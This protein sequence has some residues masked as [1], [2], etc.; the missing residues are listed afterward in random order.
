MSAG[1]QNCIL[2]ARKKRRKALCLLVAVTTTYASTLQQTTDGGAKHL[3]PRES[4]LQEEEEGDEARLSSLD[5]EMASLAQTRGVV[6]KDLKRVRDLLRR[7]KKAPKTQKQ[8]T[9]VEEAV[10]TRSSESEPGSL[11]TEVEAETQ[12][13]RHVDEETSKP[14]P[15]TSSQVR[16]TATGVDEQEEAA[17][18]ARQRARMELQQRADEEAASSADDPFKEY[19]REEEGEDEMDSE[20]YQESARALA[21][22]TGWDQGKI[23]G[24]ANDAVRSLTNAIGGKKVVATV[25]RMLGGLR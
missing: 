16:P 5:E 15:T 4:S 12:Q 20:E 3:D 23:E 19:M 18:V 22:S 8:N 25:Q 24:R 2:S 9:A 1:Y 17:T 6:A 10:T 7:K 21:K 14:R 11:H 13:H